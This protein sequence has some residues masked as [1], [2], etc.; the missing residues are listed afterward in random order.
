MFRP[1]ARLRT[2]SLL[3]APAFLLLLA[4]CG[5]ALLAPDASTITLSASPTT[6]SLTGTTTVT[7]TVTGPNGDPVPNGTMVSFETTLGTILAPNPRTSGGSAVTKLQGRGV[8]GTATVVASSG[9]VRSD[10]ID[11]TIGGALTLSVTAN[12][13]SV[14]VNDTVTFTATPGSDFTVDHYDWD[15]G[16][17]DRGV[18]NTKTTTTG[19]ATYIYVTTGTKTVT[20]KATAS[21]GSTATATTTVTV[22]SSTP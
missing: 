5:D 11:V 2:P 21:D 4:A 8:P 1:P 19:S 10:G 12:P 6:I 3:L 13:T 7:A 15:F 9:S 17:P 18:L 14:I 22:T 20:V 16:D